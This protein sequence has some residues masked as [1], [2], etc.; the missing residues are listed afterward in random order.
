MTMYDL[1]LAFVDEGPH[2]D[3]GLYAVAHAKGLRTDHELL[4]GLVGD[5]FVSVDAFHRSADLT[6]ISERAGRGLTRRPRRV[7]ARV[8]DHGILTA[9]LDDG[10]FELTPRDLQDLTSRLNRAG[11]EHQVYVLVRDERPS[12]AGVAQEQVQDAVGQL[13]HLDEP[14]RREWCLLGGLVDDGVAGYEGGTEVAAG[15]GDGVVPRHHDRRDTVGFVD[16]RVR[17]HIIAL[18]ALAPM[19]RTELGVLLQGSYSG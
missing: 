3:S 9:K 19:Q 10:L 5:G 13:E 7:N 18:E 16:H 12:G 4:Q 6:G 8:H 2:L 11:E 1:T 15:D 14:H 17:S